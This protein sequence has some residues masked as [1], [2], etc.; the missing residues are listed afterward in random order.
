MVKTMTARWPAWIGVGPR[1]LAVGRG[2]ALILALC[3]VPAVAEADVVLSFPWPGPGKVPVGAGV[4]FDLRGK[5]VV[6]LGALQFEVQFSPKLLTFREIKRGPALEGAMIEAKEVS[7]GLLKVAIV[8]SPAVTADGVL[9]TLH[10]SDTGQVG[11]ALVRLD[12]PRGWNEETLAPLTVSWVPGGGSVTF[13]NPNGWIPWAIG[14]GLALVLL[15]WLVFGRRRAPARLAPQVLV[16]P[17]ASGYAPPMTG[18]G[19]GSGR[20]C[21]NCR[22]PL[23][24]DASFCARCGQ[25]APPPAAPAFC[26]RCGKP[27]PPQ[28]K[29]CAGCGNRVNA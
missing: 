25:A 19:A 17:P 27:T 11:E 5:G 1:A 28:M 8:C 15:L 12:N 29:F 7:A 13:F 2:I 22:A 23:P 26:S 18:T 6:G 24:A 20:V 16:P 4:S 10:F 14:G 21:G 9:L 3:L